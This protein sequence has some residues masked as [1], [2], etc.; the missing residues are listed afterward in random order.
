MLENSKKGGENVMEFYYFIVAVSSIV[1]AI[2]LGIAARTI[3]ENKGYDGGFAW[4]FF[5]GWIGLIVVMSRDE[6]HSYR[7]NAEYDSRLSTYSQEVNNRRILNDGDW[8]C[9][10]CGTTNPHYQTTCICG[11]GKQEN[12][13]Y[14]INE[15]TSVESVVKLGELYDKGLISE[16]EFTAKKKQLLKL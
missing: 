12:K 3:N 6:V 2:V 8:K 13:T 16:E 1:S 11:L 15:T 5:L 10:K 14:N 4:G 7:A 9:N